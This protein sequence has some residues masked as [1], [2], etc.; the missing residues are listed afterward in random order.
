MK[1]VNAASLQDAQQGTNLLGGKLMEKSSYVKC[2]RCRNNMTADTF[3]GT[4]DRFTGWRCVMCGE[5]ID[6]VIL[7]NRQMMMA[8][9]QMA[10]GA[11]S[12][13]KMHP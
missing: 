9:Q 3:Y 7:S 5:I 2:P 4:T 12:G 11:Q 8:A 1:P 13:L 6:P 10:M